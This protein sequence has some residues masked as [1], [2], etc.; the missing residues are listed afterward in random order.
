MNK[1]GLKGLFA[2]LLL[3]LGGGFVLSAGFVMRTLQ[4]VRIG[5]E[6]YQEVIH[7][8]DVIADV[9]PPPLYLI[10]SYLLVLEAA[11][12][13]DGPQLEALHQRFSELEK[14][15][16]ERHRYW[17]SIPLQLS[18]KQALLEASWQPAQA[19]YQE[20]GRVFFPAL[21]SGDLSNQKLSLD[22]LRTFYRLHRTEVDRV[23][24]LATA[25]NQDA[26]ETAN[27]LVSSRQWML[28]GV[29][30]LIVLLS[31]GVA[32]LISRRIL[33]LLGGEPLL[34]LQL[35]QRIAA[36][37]LARLPTVAADRG[38]LLEIERMRV[39]LVALVRIIRAAVVRLETTVPELIHVAETVS[40]VAHGQSD[41]AQRMAAATEELNVSIAESS[42]VAVDS[43]RQI[44]HGQ[45][46]TDSGGEHI[47]RSVQEMG[48]I[49]ELVRA[50]S[51]EVASLGRRSGEIS[52]VTQVIQE[53]ADQTNLLALN[54][55]IE[56]AR[57]GES[58]RGF[59]VVA[60]EVRKLA[61]RTTSS[62]REI[63]VTVAAIQKDTDDVARCIHGAVVQ[64]DAVA[65]L[66]A[67]AG[68]SITAIRQMTS[69]LVEA[70]AEMSI[71]LQ[72]QG[73]ASRDIAVQVEQLS[74]Q[75]EHLAANA[76][77]NSEQAQLI[78]TLAQDLAVTVGRF[79]LGDD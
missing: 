43:K 38:L 37:N 20:A 17:Q 40:Q 33:N 2:V 34:A 35:V 46:L 66:G 61:E 15:Y 49:T 4:E 41:A 19:F 68:E 47:D 50:T 3:V 31:L 56:A 42:S 11:N 75:A 24:V 67:Q 18:L 23:V 65:G 71:A 73:G 60:D 25:F 27:T 6:A 76:G 32:A 28:S 9:L 58:G 57:A 45:V 1:L 5:S 52:A 30:L 44:D 74:Q 16:L 69:A 54:A 12:L 78:K 13:Q 62:T 55:A 53:I 36:G 79:S 70:M 10:E 64:A 7:S 26:E 63:A 51:A 39:G 14:E 21:R 8:K 72:E 77:T 48:R 59:A 22:K 29:G